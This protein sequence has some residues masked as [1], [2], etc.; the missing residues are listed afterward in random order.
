MLIEEVEEHVAL[1]QAQLYDALGESSVDEKPLPSRDGVGADDR[2]DSFEVLTHVLW[3][4]TV[5]AQSSV[6]SGFGEI[7]EYVASVKR[8]QPFQELL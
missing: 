3:G 8:R 2:M 7:E 6:A 1:R 5:L 4:P